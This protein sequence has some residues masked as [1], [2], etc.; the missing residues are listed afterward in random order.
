MTIRKNCRGGAYITVL[1]A[2]MLILML[3]AI[4]LSITAVSRRVTSRYSYFSGLFDLAVA[5]NEHALFLMRD[6]YHSNSVSALINT[7]T[8]GQIVFEQ[9]NH[10]LELDASSRARFRQTYINDATAQVRSGLNN[11]YRRTWSIDVE[12]ETDNSIIE[13]SFRAVTTVIP[14]SDRFAVNTSIH[15]Y[16]GNMPSS[17]VLVGASIIWAENSLREIPLDAHTINILESLNAFF[18]EPP[19]PGIIIFLDEF[20]LT[21]VESLRIAD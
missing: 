5:G 6:I 12:I 10:G 2:T 17:P 15:K 19:Y 18:P 21:M 16:I 3:V 4:V 20:I 7:A 8:N 14:G 11:E 9:G 13:D 1:V